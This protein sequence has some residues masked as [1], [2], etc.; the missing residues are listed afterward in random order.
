M[1]GHVVAEDRWQLAGGFLPAILHGVQFR[2][3][4]GQ[5]LPTFVDCH[6]RGIAPAKVLS[7]AEHHRGPFE[8]SEYAPIT[9]NSRLSGRSLWIVTAPLVRILAEKHGGRPVPESDR[10]SDILGVALRC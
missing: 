2:H 4:A 9:A 3:L 10:S 8:A 6:P 1:P 5:D 7:D